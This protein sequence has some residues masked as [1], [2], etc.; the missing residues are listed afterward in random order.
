M[1]NLF[2]LM[3]LMLGSCTLAENIEQEEEKEY[4]TGSYVPPL[5]DESSMATLQRLEDFYAIDPIDMEYLRSIYKGDLRVRS[6]GADLKLHWEKARN[7]ALTEWEFQKE[8]RGWENFSISK[9][10][11]ILLDENNA[12][13]FRYYEFMV[14]DSN[15]ELKGSIVIPA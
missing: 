11:R 3:V 14:L 6:G 13:F 15:N 9:R 10:P 2:F 5:V 1:K 8:E 4:Y 12:K 7:L